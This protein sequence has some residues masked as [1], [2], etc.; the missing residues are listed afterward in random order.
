MLLEEEGRGEGI[1]HRQLRRK[2]LETGRE[3][4]RPEEA[5]KAEMQRNSSCEIWATVPT[6]EED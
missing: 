5:D 2:V 4:W 1:R 3:S 6:G